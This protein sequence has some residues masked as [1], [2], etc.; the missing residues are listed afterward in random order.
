M[1]VLRRFLASMLGVVLFTLLVTSTSVGAVAATVLSGDYLADALDDA[2]FHQRV[3]AEGLPAMVRAYV[4]DQDEHA[5][6]NLRG[7][8]FPTDA[9]STAR[10]TEVIQALL[11][12]AFIHEQTDVVLREFVPWITGR[13][14]SF[15]ARVSLHEPLLA[16]FAPRGGDPSLFEVAWLD[17]D[18]SRRVMD[19]LATRQAE[20]RRESGEVAPETP[21]VL[22]RLGPNRDAAERWLDDALFEVIDAIVPFLAGEAEDFAIHLDFTPYP[23]LADPLAEI[24]NSDEETLLTEGWRFNSADFRG[25]LEDAGNPVLSDSNRFIAVF[26][27]EGARF[28]SADFVQRMEEQREEQR[29]AGDPVDGPTVE[30]VRRAMSWG[31]LAASWVPIG[32]ILLLATAIGFLGGRTWTSRGAWAGVTVVV[33]ALFALLA[34]TAMYTATVGGRFD[35]WIADERA[36]YAGSATAA[37]RDP[38]YDV[39]ESVVHGIAAAMTWRATVWLLLGM[40]VVAAAIILP[41]VLNRPQRPTPTPADI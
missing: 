8:N 2:E 14:D 12:E 17:L 28:T 37:L 19:G 32:L 41:R 27:P 31:R 13:Q 20:A 33:A 24:L 22:D 38:A 10:L 26:R 36:G 29:L 16:T 18:M 39:V 4:E 35:R 6:D 23:E 5:P 1:I 40:A 34:S 7:V 25:H 21:S 30:E 9:Q 15:E 11:P 3:H